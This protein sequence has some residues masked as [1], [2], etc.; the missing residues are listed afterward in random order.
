MHCTYNNYRSKQN[1]TEI[2]A[3]HKEATEKSQREEEWQLEQLK[4]AILQTR[5]ERSEQM[6]ALKMWVQ[7]S[8]HTKSE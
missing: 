6:Q 5:K 3:A 4:S 8:P 2:I 1:V 7:Y